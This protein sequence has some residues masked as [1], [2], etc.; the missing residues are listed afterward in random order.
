MLVS[1]GIIGTSNAQKFV[2]HHADFSSGQQN[3]WGPS[4]SP[5]TIDQ[6]ITLFNQ[7]WNVSFNTGNSG[8][9]SVAGMSFGGAFAGSFSG[10][11]GSTIEISGFTTGTVEVDYPVDIELEMNQDLEYDPGDQVTIETSY[12]V[13]S[14]WELDT[15]YPSVGEVFWNLNFQFAASATATLCAFGCVTIPVIPSFNTGL[16]SINLVTLSGS[17][18][19]TGGATGVWYLGPANNFAPDEPPAPAGGIWPYAKPPATSTQLDNGP[20]IGPG[21]WIPWQV[22]IGLFPVS[23]PDTDFGLSGEITIPYVITEDQLNT[24]NYLSACGDSTYLNLNLEIFQ[25]LGFILQQVPEPIT[26]GVGQVLSNLSG[27]QSFGIAEVSWNFF[28]ASFDMNITNKQCFDFTPRIYGKFEFPIAVSYTIQKINGTTTALDN[29]SIINFEVGD[30]VHYKF[31]CYFDSLSIVP[32]YSIDGQFRNH[33]YDS[34]SFDFLMSAF[35]FG[36]TVPAVT[37]IPGFTIPSVC[38]NVPYPCPTWKKPWKICWTNVCTPTIVVPPIGFPGFVFNYGPVWSTSIPLGGFTYNWFN[39]QWAL[40]GFQDTT[41][42]AFYMKP[43]KMG[44]SNSPTHISCNDGS[45]GSI[46]VTVDAY[47]HALPY[48]YTWTNG[49]TSAGGAIHTH[50][51]LQAGAHVVSVIDNNGC[52]LVTG[53]TL[54]EPLPLIVQHTKIDKSCGNGPNDG[55]INLTVTGGTAPYNYAWSNGFNGPTFST[56]TGLNSGTYTV[57]VT[58]TRGCVATTTVEIIEPLQLGHN[59]VITDVACFGNST[60]SIVVNT[61]GGTLPYTFTWNGSASTESISGLT[62][63][64]YELIITDNKGCTNNQV[65]VVNQPAAPLSVAISGTD[66]NCFGGA[67]GTVQSIASGGTAPYSYQW[68]KNQTYLPQ[69]TPFIVDMAIG[70]YEV[71]LTDAN[72]C[73]AT[74]SFVISGPAAPINQSPIVT[75]VLCYGDLTG[76]IVTNIAGGTPIYSYI[77]S[78]GDNTADLIN[79]ASGNYNVTVTDQ[80][81]CSENYTYTILQPNSPLAITLTPQDVK[82]FGDNTGSISSAVT[83]GSAPY[84]YDWSNGGT[85]H[86]I[87]GLAAGIYTLA[88]TDV[89]GC[90]LLESSTVT[91]PAAPISYGFTVTDVD[92]FGN[93]SGSVDLTVAGGTSPYTYQWTNMASFIL[94]DTT[95]DITNQLAGNYAVIITDANGCQES[96]SVTISQPTA[97]LAI[98]GIVQHIDCFGQNTGVISIDVTGGTSGYLYNWSDGST[99]QNLSNALAG[100][101]TLVVTDANGCTTES[102]FN[103]NQPEAPL[104]VVITSQDAKCFDALTGNAQSFAGG[105]TA[106]Y[107]YLWSNG[108]TANQLVNVGANTYTLTVTDT[109]GCTAFSGTTINQPDEL[110][111]APV[112]TDV[113][114]YGYSD[115][116]I[117]VNITGGV[118]PYY[119]TWGNQNNIIL[120]NPSETLSDLPASDYLIRIKDANNCMSEMTLTVNQPPVYEAL[121]TVTNTSC[122]EGADGSIEMELIGGTMPYSSEW[123]NGAL[124][125]DIFSLTAGVYSYVTTDD[126]GCIIRGEAQVKQPSEIKITYQI[127]P[128]TCI[129]QSDASIEASA[130]GGTPPFQYAWDNGE[131]GN[132]IQELAP[133]IY[134]LTVTDDNNCENTFSFDVTQVFNECLVIPNTFTPNGDNYNDT[135]VLGNIEL[136]PNATVKVFNKWGNEIF[137]NDNT[138]YQPW[139]GTH[140]GNAL[141]SGVFYYII[142]LNNEQNNQYTGTVTIVR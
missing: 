22:H 32:T 40:E 63:G 1:I 139:E 44:I 105:G 26:Q 39:Q 102:H 77:W 104:S 60:G 95:Q 4:F 67:D 38:V 94:S 141:P 106:P 55:S 34:V 52:Q 142:L 61:F 6:T 108:S 128:V 75:N 133:G 20:G 117:V 72:G 9:V 65:Y 114:C 79:V 131:L 134:E 37:V 116:E 50:S 56:L 110:L 88:I 69:T 80:N 42:N 16:Q 119:F 31:P 13:R 121:L 71:I 46:E 138:P 33:T 97:P 84:A 51:N 127:I 90:Q 59:A 58:D 96:D 17:G 2:N 85:T 129:D 66:V 36:I 54:T 74:N 91:Q 132:S 19:S 100:S 82:C 123:S 112:I 18:A 10:S 93:N 64:N 5:I 76:S 11:I 73:S 70:T 89:N 27:S 113:S 45:D 111:L 8:I 53:A 12:S 109:K 107:T 24:N 7:P 98:A 101:Y 136:Y 28:S 140:N 118:Q 25:L 21:N 126:Q 47:S 87:A 49:I 57:T 92:C 68:I 15:K 86:N 137:N 30:V 135:W 41:F 23:L 103:I 35:A 78:N 124:T 130:F 99:N 29:S 48:T 120:N 62:A 81:G 115:G 125:H 83:G 122:F 43:Y 3:M 14:G